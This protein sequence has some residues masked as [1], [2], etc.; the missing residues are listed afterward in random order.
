VLD[1]AGAAAAEAA[2]PVEDANGSP[3]YKA[4]LVRVLLERTLREATAA[5][6]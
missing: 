1:E 6:A 3:A 2:S 4:Q 5:V